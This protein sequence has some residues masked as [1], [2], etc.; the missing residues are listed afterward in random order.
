MGRVGRLIHFMLHQ[1]RIS[2]CRGAV[3]YCR[4]L[5][6]VVLVVNVSLMVPGMTARRAGVIPVHKALRV[7]MQ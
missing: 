3:V 7:D 2:V 6:A 1:Q 4:W 5:S